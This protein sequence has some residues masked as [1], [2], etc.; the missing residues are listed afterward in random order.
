PLGNHVFHCDK[1]HG[2]VDMDAAVVHS[3][4][5]YFYDMCRRVGAEKLAPMVRSMGF[6]EKCDLPFDNQRYGT[7]P[8]PDW[9][10]RKYHR[11]WQ[12]YD[13]INMSIGQ[14]NVL[15][16]PLQLAVMASRLSTG[17]RV[18]PR[19]LKQQ[20]IVP[21]MSLGIDQ[22]H[23]DFIH[24]AMAGVVDHGTAA[25]AKLPLANVQMAG[26]TGTA[27]VRRITMAERNS[28]GVRS[29]ESLAWKM[30]DHSLFV[31]FAPAMA[32]RYAAACVIEHG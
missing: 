12:T 6:G 3:C 11:E 4:D 20:K 1:R 24:A 22:D 29:N 26:K 23:L 31:A 13:T 8:D 17:R 14:G 2:P 28:G 7:I 18:L 15:V 10:M 25:G 32:P 21:Q 19:L 27:Q 5:I 9:M 30:R 16:N